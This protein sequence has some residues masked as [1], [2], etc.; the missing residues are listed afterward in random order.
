MELRDFRRGVAPRTAPVIQRPTGFDVRRSPYAPAPRVPAVAPTQSK[1]GSPSA[2]GFKPAYTPPANT[3]SKPLFPGQFP[4]QGSM[5]ATTPLLGNSVKPNSIPPFLLR[6]LPD[7]AVDATGLGIVAPPLGAFAAGLGE[8]AAQKYE[9]YTGDRKQESPGEVALAG[10]A[11]LLPALLGLFGKKALPAGIKAISGKM[12]RVLP[13]NYPYNYMQGPSLL[14]AQVNRG[15]E[16]AN[17]GLT[18]DQYLNPNNIRVVGSRIGRPVVVANQAG[19]PQHFYKSTAWAKKVDRYG[20]S[21]E[22][23]WVPY[24]GHIDYPWIRPD[25]P[26]TEN[27]F[28]KGD[29][30]YLKDIT[31]AWDNAYGVPLHQQVSQ[32][33]DEALMQ[34]IF[35]RNVSEEQLNALLGFK[36]KYAENQFVIPRVA[37]DTRVGQVLQ[38]PFYYTSSK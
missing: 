18:V 22:G 17:A 16:A 14:Q 2:V 35:G 31:A 20:N 26:M 13:N 23:T 21:S 25:I 34:K 4:M 15:L 36:N 6:T 30:N 24:P 9:M 3:A 27:W 19:L 33:L 8:K 38:N 12:D 1:F 29:R 11:G 5:G 10:A 32:N 28:I 37:A 7:F